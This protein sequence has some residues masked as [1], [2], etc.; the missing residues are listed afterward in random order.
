MENPKPKTDE[1]YCSCCGSIIKR[2]AEI[3]VNC[4]VRVST[5]PLAVGVVTSDK[6][7]LAAGLLGILL[8]GIGVHRFY[9]GNIGIGIIQIIVTIITL[10]IGSLWGFIEGIIIIAGANWKDAEGMPLKKWSET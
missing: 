10:G 1:M 6:S 4:G 2:Q 3:C 5:Q 7:R 8:G 9:L